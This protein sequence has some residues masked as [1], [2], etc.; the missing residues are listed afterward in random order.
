MNKLQVLKEVRKLLESDESQIVKLYHGSNSKNIRALSTNFIG[1]RGVSF[2][3]GFYFTNDIEIA[4]QYGEY[5]YEADVTL[6]KVLDLDKPTQDD[7]DTIAMYITKS[8]EE[9]GKEPKDLSDDKD[10]FFS[11]KGSEKLGMFLRE[12]GNIDA[13]LSYGRYDTVSLLHGREIVVLNS[14]NIKNLRII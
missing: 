11:I 3:T 10:T 4:K 6:G 1:K 14:D 8:R 5:I 7:W 12:L 9:K 13:I 2:G